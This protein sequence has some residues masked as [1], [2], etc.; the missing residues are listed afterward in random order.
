MDPAQGVGGDANGQAVSLRLL[1]R[2]ARGEGD[3]TQLAGA[4]ASQGGQRGAR[5]A[6][7]VY[8]GATEDEQ[9]LKLKKKIEEE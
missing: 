6:G 1:H 9:I 5:G 8:V 3:S 2:A 7:G 4:F